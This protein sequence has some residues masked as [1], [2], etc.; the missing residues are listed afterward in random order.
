MK[1]YTKE[2]FASLAS[3]SGYDEETLSYCVKVEEDGVYPIDGLEMLPMSWRWKP[4]HALAGQPGVDSTGP[5]LP[6]DFTAVDLAGFLLTS[7]AVFITEI[8]GDI[9]IGPKALLDPVDYG[10]AA[11]A[12]I[13]LKQA[14]EILQ[15]AMQ[16]IGKPPSQEIHAADKASHAFAEAWDFAL[17]AQRVLERGIT[18]QEYRQ[19]HA[20]ATEQTAEIRK[21][22]DQLNE[23]AAEQLKQW[24]LAISR[25]LFSSEIS[26]TN[27]GKKVP[28]VLKNQWSLKQDFRIRDF[29]YTRILRK[30]MQ[31]LID[32]N[33]KPTASTVLAYWQSQKP[34][35]LLDVKEQY[36]VLKTANSAG[37][38]VMRKDLQNAIDRQLNFNRSD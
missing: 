25:Y 30:A 21:L 5:S 12:A 27:T 26:E 15:A 3:I 36:F 1:K 9:E 28:A 10:D 24:R 18:D 19:R 34:E 7:S 35:Q 16:K 23:A 20:I 37:K 2:V 8:W 31:A 4:R 17:K 6:F 22:R 38:K 33:L 14:Y 32:Q 29:S 11:D 13:V